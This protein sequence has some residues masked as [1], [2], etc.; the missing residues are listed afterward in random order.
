[1]YSDVILLPSFISLKVYFA[2]KYWF[3]ISSC[4]TT[5]AQSSPFT[6]DKK[7]AARFLCV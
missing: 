3:P 2:F 5:K 1:M 6:V 4:L 7:I